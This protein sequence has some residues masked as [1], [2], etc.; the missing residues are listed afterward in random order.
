VPISETRLEVVDP[1]LG[2]LPFGQVANEPG[3]HAIIADPGLANRKFD[4]KGRPIAMAGRQHAPNPDDPTLTGTKVAFQISVMP[5]AIRRRHEHAHI[6]SENLV[7]RETEHSFG[8][9]AERQNMP[10]LVDD[11]HRIGHRLQD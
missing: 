1:K 2:L 3:E 10:M 8:G 7:L 6:F 4:W 9:G 11:H 5:F